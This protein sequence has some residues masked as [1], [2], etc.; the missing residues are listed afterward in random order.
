MK[1]Y[2][3][4]DLS[5]DIMIRKGGV[6][7]RDFPIFTTDFGV[8]SLVL[9]E[10]P[11]RKEAYIRIRDASVEHFAAHLEECVEFCK[12]AGAERIFAAG[13]DCLEAY[14]LYTTVLE[15]RSTV[16]V[17]PE[18]MANLFP[19]TEQTVSRWRSIYNERMRGVDNATTLES[20]DEKQ[21]L[22][23]GGAYFVHREG[24]L[25]GIGWMQDSKV[26]AMASV[27]PGAGEAVLRTLL[28]LASQEQATLEVASTNHRAIRLYKKMG[29]LVV[30]EV[31]RWYCVYAQKTDE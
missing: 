14:P 21:I 7:L 4:C 19:V 18:Q 25:L 13:H 6:V 22:T 12:M 11:Y 2:L 9:K 30:R 23:S 16:Q 5:R 8:S 24:Q 31:S 3:N 17:N 26:L 1:W 10:V 15:M 27:V 20:R 28:S 29:F